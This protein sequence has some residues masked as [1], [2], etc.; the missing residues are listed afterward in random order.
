MQPLTGYS[1]GGELNQLPITIIA[2]EATIEA[3]LRV[4]LQAGT[5]VEVFGTGFDFEL[6]VYVDLFEYTAVAIGESHNCGLFIAERVDLAVGVYALFV[7]DID[8][9]AFTA[10]PA[11]F[12]VLL[13]LDLPN[14][15]LATPPK[16]HHSASGY[17]T[18]PTGT[19]YPTAYPTSSP[20]GEGYPS[21]SSQGYLTLPS[22]TENPPGYPTGYP[23]GSS[24]TIGAPYPTGTASASGSSIPSNSANG[25]IIA[26]APLTTATAYS[27]TSY[28]ITSC[29]ATGLH[30]PASSSSQIVVT[31]VCPVTGTQTPAAPT[32]VAYP[33]KTPSSSSAPQSLTPVPTPTPSTVYTPTTCTPNKT[34]VSATSYP[35]LNPG[36]TG[37]V[38][39][40]FTTYS[41]G[42]YPTSPAAPSGVAAPSGYS[43]HATGSVPTS[44]P[45][46]FTGGAARSSGTVVIALAVALFGAVALM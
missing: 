42:E 34:I 8:Y 3:S 17:P 25:T 24:A 38:A 30:C 45:A 23:T 6:G 12:I 26:S 31:A 39:P 13:E 29:A 5:T 37:T 35:V 10:I 19:G 9:R 15:C 33:V 2:G 18:L 11:V 41:A 27:T 40:V 7:L 4:R 14:I 43:A 22:G 21:Q 16:H 46:P 28:T 20:S 32:T 36:Y 1:A 44:P